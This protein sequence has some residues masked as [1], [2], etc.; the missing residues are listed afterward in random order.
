MSL[1]D[2]EADHHRRIGLLQ[3]WVGA[4]EELLES[5]EVVVALAHLLAVDGDHIVVNPIFHRFMSLSGYTLSYLTLMMG[6]KK[7][8]AASVDVETFSKIFLA[9]RGAFEMPARETFAPGR[10]PVHDMLRSR[11]LPEGKVERIAL[12]VLPVE[13]A[14]LGLHVFDVSARKLAIVMI[15]VILLDIEIY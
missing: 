7:V 13:V 3:P 8:E 11:F 9:H 2:E 4:L 15:F 1:K 10:G 12:L 6:E 5:D 14:G